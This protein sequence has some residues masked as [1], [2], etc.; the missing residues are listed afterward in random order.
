MPET[1][2]QRLHHRAIAQEV[3]PLVI[4]QVRG[5]D[6]GVLTVT[7]LDQLEEDVGLFRMKTGMLSDS[8]GEPKVMVRLVE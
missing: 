8:R 2:Q 1:A 7:L 4:H 3:R 6:R 5:D